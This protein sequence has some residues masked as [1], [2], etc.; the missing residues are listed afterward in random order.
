MP[1]SQELLVGLARQMYDDIRFIT[2]H[3]PTQVVDDDT[4]RVFNTLLLEVQQT[5]RSQ[6]LVFSFNEMAARTVTSMKQEIQHIADSAAIH[7]AQRLV[8]EEPN[9]IPAYTIE[10]D[11]IEKLKR[12]Y[13]FAKR[14]AKTVET[15]EDETV[16]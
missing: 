6:P 8:A 7:Q 14:M 15:D 10:I 13:Y 11:I 3:N 12:I 1:G 2:E 16:S 9:R 5:F 4:A